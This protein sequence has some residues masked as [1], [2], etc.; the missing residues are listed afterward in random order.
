MSDFKLSICNNA[1]SLIGQG[2]TLSS[3]DDAKKEALICKRVYDQVILR[4][5]DKYNFSFVRKDEYIDESFLIADAVSLP[6]IFTY[7]LPT[8]VMRILYIAPFDATA[9]TERIGYLKP[10]AFNFRLLKGQK[11]LVTNE[12]APFTLQYQGNDFTEVIFPPT[13]IEAVEFLLAGAIAPEIIKG[14]TGLQVANGLYQRGLQL[15]DLSA[16]LDAQQGGSCI[17]PVAHMN[18]LTRSRF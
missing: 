1:L 9:L 18:A 7:R 11:V 13:F 12:P 3:L 8:D 15:L 6:W 4:A 14:S 10:I 2:Q 5:L 17:G 16:S